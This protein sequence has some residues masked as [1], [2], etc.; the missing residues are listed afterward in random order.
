MENQEKASPGLIV[1]KKMG[2]QSA[3][4]GGERVLKLMPRG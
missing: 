2:A 4:T 1:R 3:H